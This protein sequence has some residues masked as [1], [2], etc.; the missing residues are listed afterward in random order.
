MLRSV[1]LDILLFCLSDFP[2]F[3]CFGSCCVLCVVSHRSFA[4][5]CL[6]VFLPLSR[7][8][9]F[10]GMLCL[11]FQFFILR[12]MSSFCCT[13]CY[14]AVDPSYF[15]LLFACCAITRLSR[16]NAIQHAT[17]GRSGHHNETQFNKLKKH[18]KTHHKTR[19]T[20][21]HTNKT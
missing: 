5:L 11:A 15:V 1:V 16:G 10:H 9:V 14:G 6:T 2:A 20:M 13:L 8:R 19:N 12:F 21:K 7:C 3:L 4:V 18:N 17:H